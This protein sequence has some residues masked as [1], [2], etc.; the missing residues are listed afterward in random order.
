METHAEGRESALYSLLGHKGDLLVVHFRRSFEE[1]NQA[2]IELARLRLGDYLEPATSYLSVSSS[3][4]RI[5]RESVRRPRVQGIDPNSEEWKTG[6]EEVLAR[7]RTPWRPGC[8]R[9]FPNP[10]TSASTPWT[11]GAANPSTGIASPWRTAS[12]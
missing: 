12:A 10:N 7:Q 3:A 4:V 11:A 8:G 1:L 6:I 2:E 5:L 9:A